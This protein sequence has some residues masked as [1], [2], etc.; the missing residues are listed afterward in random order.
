M[1]EFNLL[2]KIII[3]LIPIIFAI[4]LHEVAHGWVAYRLGDPT[5]KLQK[6]L[7]LNPLRHI[8]LLGTLI[9]PI[10]LLLTTGFVFGWAKPVPVNWSNLHNPRRDTA[11]VAI[12]GPLTN[13]LMAIFW[14]LALRYSFML[15]LQN[16]AAGTVLL[17]MSN[18]GVSINILL[19]VLN[20]I[21]IPPLDGSR[22]LASFLPARGQYLLHRIE[23]FGFFILLIL[24]VSGLLGSFLYPAV[25]GLKSFIRV[26][27]NF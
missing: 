6:R 13:L 5:A 12:A 11:L 23:P 20:L 3:W 8:D 14:A 17:Y 24:L 25:Q 16:I 10:G 22:V 15:S 7:S 26:L 1:I 21:P 18:I 9:I 2:Q 19:C 27:L 4:T